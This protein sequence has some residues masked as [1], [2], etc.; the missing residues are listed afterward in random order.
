MSSS[1]SLDQELPNVFPIF[2]S[3]KKVAKFWA[4]LPKVTF[5][6]LTN[7]FA[8]F[9][10]FSFF[11]LYFLDDVLWPRRQYHQFSNFSHA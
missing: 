3:S 4:T 2:Y 1:N 5:T 7:Y 6:W 11:F 8:P 9:D 10:L